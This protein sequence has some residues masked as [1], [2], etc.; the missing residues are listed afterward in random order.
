MM[1]G[2]GAN[3]TVGVDLSAEPARTAICVVTWTRGT[4]HVERLI[5]PAEDADVLDACAGAD[6]VGIDCPF[7]WP[8]PFV[9]AVSAHVAGRPWPGRHRIAQHY[10]R[11]LRYRATDYYV[12]DVTGRWPLSVSTDRIGVAAM[13]CAILLDTLTERGT[14]VDRAGS[15]QVVEVYPA[16]ALHQWQILRSGYKHDGEV[17]DAMVSDLLAQLPSLRFPEGD[18]PFRRSDH[19]F[20]A[21]VCA[22]VARAAQRGA[23]APP[24]T[25]DERRR[26][27]SEG[28]IHLPK[29]GRGSLAELVTVDDRPI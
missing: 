7:G 4:A 9:S 14:P 20:D 25:I 3:R 6:R 17:L 12:H 16:A 11:Q 18:Q 19:D 22:L 1:V 2:M 27:A 10:R 21:L 15:G 23:T 8:E 5:R 28:W 26:A 29:D 13:R 24:H